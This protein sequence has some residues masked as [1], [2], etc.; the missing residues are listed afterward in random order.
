MKR[1]NA[2]KHAKPR[3]GRH[4]QTILDRVGHSTVKIGL[5]FFQSTEFGSAQEAA[6]RAAQIKRA[7][8]V[9][10]PKRATYVRPRAREG[11]DLQ[12]VRG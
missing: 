3:F 7:Q 11:R 10:A 4:V 12:D 1:S 2:A 5:G 6:R 9:K 8:I